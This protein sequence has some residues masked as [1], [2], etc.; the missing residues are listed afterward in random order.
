MSFGLTP[1]NA[2]RSLCFAAIHAEEAAGLWWRC[3][4]LNPILIK[5]NWKK[6]QVPRR[7]IGKSCPS[8]RQI[9]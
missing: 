5:G 3:I 8:V 7:S 2:L 1:K 4:S 6:R 9:Y